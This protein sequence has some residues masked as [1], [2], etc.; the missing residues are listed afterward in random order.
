[1]D[2]C[3]VFSEKKM[4]VFVC[5]ETPVQIFPAVFGRV[6]GLRVPSVLTALSCLCVYISQYR[7][8]HCFRC[9]AFGM[10]NPKNEDASMC[11][12]G[13]PFHVGSSLWP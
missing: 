4:C 12:A 11:L 6:Y 3:F 9:R 13:I 7:E 5:T 2:S 8:S 1:M 10:V